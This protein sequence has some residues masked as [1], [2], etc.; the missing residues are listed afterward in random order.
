MS[1]VIANS[2]SNWISSLANTFLKSDMTTAA[3]DG[4]F[5]YA[6]MLGLLTDVENR[7]S[8]T[9]SEFSDLETIAANLNIGISTSSYLA[10]I[11]SQLVDG[12]PANAMWNGGSATATSLGDLASGTS[13][14][15]LSRLIGTWFLGTDLPDPTTSGGT[16]LTYQTSTLPLYGSTGAPIVADVSQG[17]L[18]D[19][20][21]CATMM[22]MANAEPGTIQSNI[23]SV[24]NGIYG[25]RFY[26]DG[27]ET[28]VTVNSDLPVNSSG[29]LVYMNSGNGANPPLW[30]DLYEKAY[31]QLSS[32]GLVGHPADD[33]F[34]NIDGNMNI[35]VAYAMTGANLTAYSSSD[36]N[37]S[38]D[39]AAIV[40]AVTAG[41]V[42]IFSS[43]SDTTDSNG[44][45]LLVSSH[46]F[47]IVGYDSATGD[48]IVRNPW[49]DKGSWQNW[50]AQFEVSMSDLTSAKA[51]I[52]VAN[53]VGT[54][55]HIITAQGSYSCWDGWYSSTAVSGGSSYTQYLGIGSSV[56]ICGLFKTIDATGA[57][58]TQYLLQNLGPGSI[59]L[60]GAV[61]LATSD[62]IAQGQ[63]LV[64]AADLAKLNYTAPSS[65]GYTDLLVSAYD[66]ANWSAPTDVA[67][68][69]F[70]YAEAAI[71]PNIGA[72]VG[73]SGTISIS[74]LFNVPDS[75]SVSYYQVTSNDGTINLNGANSWGSGSTVD[76][77]ASDLSKL[78]FT[79]PST[80]GIVQLEVWACTG[81]NWSTE[82]GVQLLVGET[83]ADAVQDYDNGLLGH[84]AA[85]AD[86]AAN[87]FANLDGLQDMVSA[88]V[89]KAVALTN[90][91]T[92]TEKI[93]ASQRARDRG[94]LSILSGSYN[95][96]VSGTTMSWSI[97][98]DGDWST[99]ADWYPAR[100][101]NSSDAV[102]VDTMHFHT[103]TYSSGTTTI[104]SLV[105]G[106]DDVAVQGGTLQVSGKMTGSGGLIV[107][108]GARFVLD[109]SSTTSANTVDVESG[110]GAVTLTGGSGKDSFTFGALLAS[111]R[112]DGG[113]GTDTVNLDG[114]YSAGLTFGSKTMVNVENV[115]LV[116]GYSYKIMT[117]DATV[118]AGQSLTVN[119]S[120]LGSSSRLRFN[121]SAET[122]G[123]FSI[124]GGAGNDTITG[125]AGNDTLSGSAG[126]DLF[127]ISYGGMDVVSGGAGNDA[128]N[129]GGAFTAKDRIDGGAGTD[130]AKLDGD[131]S[132]GVT[133]AS[134]TLVNVETLVLAAGHSYKLATDDA[135]VASGA[136]LAVNASALDASNW[137][138]FK[139]AAETN[140][141]FVVTGG[142]GKD[143]LTGGGGNDTLTGGGG[144][145]SLVGGAGADTFVYTQASDSSG[146]TF[147]TVTGFDATSDKIDIW[148]KVYGVDSAVT[149]GKLWSSTFDTDLASI[150]TGKLKAHHAVLVTPNGGTYAGQQFLVIDTNGVA[151]YQ[152]G[153]DLV[154]KL[155]S[156]LN[157]LSLN[158][159]TFT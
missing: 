107:D 10:S 91:T 18:G 121:G 57:A 77:N 136:T 128:I 133:F 124:T 129:C 49:G 1:I 55:I 70:A 3:A 50:N 23:V 79:A 120:A 94:V 159:G 32:T 112:I 144:A 153:A 22:E 26:I 147:D 113:T 134:T 155:T 145:D 99:I 151:G 41:E 31:A 56:P 103:V 8:V 59:D 135:T 119:A 60:N 36:T 44:K 140:G 12:S 62:Q 126:A 53:T 111:D 106:N 61:N 63:I 25:V 19:C 30:A 73:A 43:S 6:E 82:Q 131:Y 104:A 9:A 100:L 83:A 51:W 67:L 123:K 93:S 29:S 139:G 137:L 115:V 87:I 92:V 96:A 98:S 118:A 71:L 74:S 2:N 158:S 116:A 109:A 27:A 72:V 75:A 17:G 45:T 127:D 141:R 89:L 38:Y 102:G 24:G 142:A 37:W 97:D 65:S 40:A 15:N 105:I 35:T 110:T 13:Q 47:A 58:I 86:S 5:S 152:A 39:K 156:P 48:F 101:P 125:G 143:T 114:D 16:T 66:G 146:N 76:V 21:V 4:E 122:N 95:L 69:I 90:G 84:A 138:V 108:S 64:S 34:E 157:I 20:V 78:T 52:C 150:L 148:T 130:T 14:T 88:G 68:S 81:S 7:G 132:A 33:S 46:D 149:A 117:N 42:V 80:T 154:I 28:W 11:F 85:V 54:P